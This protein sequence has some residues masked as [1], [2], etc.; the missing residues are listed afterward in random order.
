MHYGN[1]M[2]TAVIPTR[3]RPG[4][5]LRAVRSALAQ[6]YANIEVIV[7]VDGPDQA[8]VSA[9]ETMQASDARL[10]I[11]PLPQSVGACDTRN[12]GI[13]AARG[14]WIA[15]LDDD[16]EWMPQKLEKQIAL[17]ERSSYSLPVISSRMVLRTPAIDRI[18]PR[19][20][21][22]LPFADYAVLRT[23]L[24]PGEGGLQTSTLVARSALFKSC[25]FTSGLPRHQELDWLI[26][27]VDLPGV[28]LEFVPEPLSIWHVDRNRAAIGN[29]DDWRSSL[30]WVNQMRSHFSAESYAS[31]VL[32][33]V[34]ASASNQGDWRAF[35]PLLIL[36]A[37]KG[38]PTPVP[39][40]FFLL[41]W[42]IPHHLRF[43][44]W[45]MLEKRREHSETANVAT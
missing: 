24:L 38:R 5:V 37:R 25:L 2:V 35:L 6:T 28:G 26:R 13:K 18:W 20:K 36:A 33:R 8:T 11:L 3:N 39:L 27:A 22:F 23:E 21:P 1:P 14:E 42:I 4:L 44:I 40:L 15:L 41:R 34:G 45:V 19:N 31:F 32:E 30:K 16:D 12:A 10:R 7:V 17:G 9:L 43:P 29:S